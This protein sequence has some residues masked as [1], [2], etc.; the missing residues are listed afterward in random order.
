MKG[1]REQRFENTA[2]EKAVPWCQRGTWF[3]L[4]VPGGAAETGF[5]WSAGWLDQLL[6]GTS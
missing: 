1:S 2:I 3:R 6:C 4:S 5:Q